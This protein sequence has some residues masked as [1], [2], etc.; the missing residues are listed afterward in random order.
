MNM[1]T[2]D[3]FAYD[4][5]HPIRSL[6]VVDLRYTLKTGGSTLYMM[7]AS[8]LGGD[9]RSLERLMC[10]LTRYLACLKYPE[11]L[12][13][14]GEPTPE[15]ST[16]IVKLHPDSS[17]FAFELLERNKDWVRNNDATL[18]IDTSEIVEY[19]VH[20]LYARDDT[21]PIPDLEVL[22]INVVRKGGGSDLIIIIASPLGDDRRS[23][24]RLMMKIEQYLEFA[25]SDEFVAE[26]GV[27][28]V[29]NTRIIVHIHPDS[30]SAAFDLLYRKR[31]WVRDNGVTLVIDTAGIGYREH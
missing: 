28:T 29:D 7:V 8:P 27:S 4:E 10:K 6:D 13:A 12:A 24:E 18:V 31:E 25:K 9:R 11:C 20:P 14:A 2:D 15:N 1:T 5:G 26:S 3:Y 19:T 16:I 30:S 22:D 21:H 23:L 17:P